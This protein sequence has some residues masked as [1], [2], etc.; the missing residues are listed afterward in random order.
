MICVSSSRDPVYIYKHISLTFFPSM[1]G[2][3]ICTLLCIFALLTVHFTVVWHL[4]IDKYLIFFLEGC[5]FCSNLQILYSDIPDG[6]MTLRHAVCSVSLA[7]GT[8]LTGPCLLLERCLSSVDPSRITSVTWCLHISLL[9][10]DTFILASFLP[11]FS[12]WTETEL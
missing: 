12:P 9:F 3:W 2:S 5:L 7:S 8:I 10:I 6:W 11:D 1:N 4:S